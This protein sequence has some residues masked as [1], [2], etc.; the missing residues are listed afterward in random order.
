MRGAAEAITCFDRRKWMEL[1]TK[2]LLVWGMGSD[3]SGRIL[4]EMLQA[5][6]AAQGM[7]DSRATCILILRS[8][9]NLFPTSQASTIGTFCDEME[10][11][12]DP[13]L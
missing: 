13:L 2:V 8:H 3:E 4:D 1:F 7:P 9:A 10:R 12:D 5:M 6:L 11:D